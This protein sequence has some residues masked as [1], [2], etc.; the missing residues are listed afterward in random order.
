MRRYIGDTLSRFGYRP[1]LAET[2]NEAL[3][4]LAKASAPL[5]LLLTDVVLPEMSG[6]HLAQRL[7]KLQPG[8]RV[9]FMSGHIDPRAGHAALPADAELPAQ[10]VSPRRARARRAHGCSTRA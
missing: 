10:A 6:M 7:T 2:P 3:A 1:V 8:L 9:V 5:D 4:L